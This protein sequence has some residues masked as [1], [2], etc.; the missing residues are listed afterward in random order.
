VRVNA[1][2]GR[3]Y[4]TAECDI[5]PKPGVSEEE[6]RINANNSGSMG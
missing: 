1:R 4:F 3:A 5:P 2:N 6:L